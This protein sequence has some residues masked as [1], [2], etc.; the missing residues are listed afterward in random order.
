[1]ARPCSFSAYV[2]PGSGKILHPGVLAMAFDLHFSGLASSVAPLGPLGK[3]SVALAMSL[4]GWKRSEF[5]SGSISS[6]MPD[7]QL[8]SHYNAK[9][10]SSGPPEGPGALNVGHEM[11]TASPFDLTSAGAWPKERAF[12]LAA[13]LPL[14]ASTY[15]SDNVGA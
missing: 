10:N 15:F 12:S 9:I 6:A 11:Y 4:A 8:V 13:L 1:M 5:S 3:P 7:V 14:H 2:G